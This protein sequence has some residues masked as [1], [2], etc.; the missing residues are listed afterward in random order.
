MAGWP[1]SGEGNT[2]PGGAGVPGAGAVLS[3]FS[4]RARGA[5]TPPPLYA[6][7]CAFTE[8]LASRGATV[9]QMSNH[10]TSRSDDVAVMQR[11]SGI[12]LLGFPGANR[13][14]DADLPTAHI[15]DFVSLS[16]ALVYMAVLFDELEGPAT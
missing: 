12:V 11:N 3:E 13:H 5:V 8:R 1:A 7:V 2:G 16:R 9:R 6:A 10:Y 4:S 15:D 14:F